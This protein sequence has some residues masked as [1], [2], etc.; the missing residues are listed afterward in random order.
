MKRGCLCV[1]RLREKQVN[2]LRRKKIWERRG[3]MKGEVVIVVV[4]RR[5]A[6]IGVNIAD[7]LIVLVRCMQ[8]PAVAVY[9][10]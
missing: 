4:G 10:K 2:K 5:S 3:T 1:R 9:E 8:L 6:K 7:D